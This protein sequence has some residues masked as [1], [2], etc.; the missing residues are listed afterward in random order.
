MTWQ[1]IISGERRWAVICA[2]NAEIL[3]Q[4]P[5]KSVAH[6]IT[7]PPYSDHVHGVHEDNGGGV[8]RD[9]KTPRLKDL[10]FESLSEDCAELVARH[11]AR[12]CMRWA[13][14][15]CDAEGTFRWMRRGEAAGLD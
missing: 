9:G 2:D 13:I 11:T 12:I 6:V 4:L 5:D 14:F 10:G 8:R 15:F 1:S 3:P 7:D